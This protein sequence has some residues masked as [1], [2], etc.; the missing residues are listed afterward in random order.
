MSDF[1]LGEAG[2]EQRLSRCDC[3]MRQ[4][5]A[6]IGREV[7]TASGTLVRDVVAIKR[8]WQFRYSWLPAK[9]SYVYDGGMGRDELYAL[10]CLKKALSFHVP[11]QDGAVEDVTVQF[12]MDSWDEHL[13]DTDGPWGWV[14][15]VS[16]TLVEV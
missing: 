3:D 14:Y 1:E 16:F 6:M 2:S 13:I 15:E 11:S 7:R 12:A 8:T 10:Y 5:A 9:K 4:G